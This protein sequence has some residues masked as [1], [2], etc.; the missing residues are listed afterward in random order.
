VEPRIVELLNKLE[1]MRERLPAED[2]LVVNEAV[3]EICKYN[4][5]V[6]IIEQIKLPER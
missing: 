3:K 1:A 5:D 6:K 2:Y 4:Q